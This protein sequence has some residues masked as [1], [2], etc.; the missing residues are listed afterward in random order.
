MLVW[1]DQ[2]CGVKMMIKIA[3]W[4]R[5]CTTSVSTPYHITPISKGAPGRTADRMR[6]TVVTDGAGVRLSM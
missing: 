5:G 4:R 3:E 1:D 2:A 6:G